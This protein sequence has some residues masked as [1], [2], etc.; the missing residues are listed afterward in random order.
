M[1][2]KTILIS[3][4]ANGIGLGIVQAALQTGANAIIADI[5]REALL[6]VERRLRDYR[7]QLLCC[8][9]DVTSEP[10][11]IECLE[12]IDKQFGKLH[13]LVNNAAISDPHNDPLDQLPLQRW[14]RLLNHNLTSVFLLTK[15]SLPRLRQ[16]LGAIVNIASTRALQSEPHSEVYA[17]SKGGVVALTHAVAIS[18]GP[19]VRANCILPGWIHTSSEPLREED[20]QQHPAG[21]VGEPADIAALTLF[22]LGEQSRF[23]TGQSFVVDG[24][25]TRKMI[26]AP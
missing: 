18:E 10:Q 13:G 4:G 21:R 1:N 19:K 15:H 9:V 6:A 3:G 25:M 16:Q 8:H 17:A 26:Y 12:Q 20:H 14:Q 11:V 2:K 5:D 22:L 7:N 24:G 23:I